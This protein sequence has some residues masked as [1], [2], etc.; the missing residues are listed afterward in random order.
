MKRKHGKRGSAAAAAE[1]GYGKRLAV[2]AA[3]AV[4]VGLFTGYLLI[5]PGITL[6][7]ENPAAVSLAAA[8]GQDGAAPEEPGTDA[9]GD[10][11][12]PPSPEDTAD[13]EETPALGDE[14]NGGAPAGEDPPAADGAE[15]DALPA[16]GEAEE[17]GPEGGEETPEPAQ[18]PEEPQQPEETTAGEETPPEE[19]RM[20]CRR[21]RNPKIRMRSQSLRTGQLGRPWPTAVTLLIGRTLC[22]RIQTQHS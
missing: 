19:M 4:A 9:R 3:L 18:E 2:V 1:R 12:P 22:G 20:L 17:G 8:A 14:E 6:E 5:L 7:E 16:D 13:G 11:E 15:E 10:A 21:K